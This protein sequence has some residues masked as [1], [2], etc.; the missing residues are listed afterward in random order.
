MY[1]NNLLI[2]QV[3]YRKY[4]AVILYSLRYIELILL[5]EVTSRD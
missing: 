4:L 5:M 3:S 1:T 2:L